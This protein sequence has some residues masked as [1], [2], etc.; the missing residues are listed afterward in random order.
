MGRTVPPGRQHGLLRVGQRGHDVVQL[1]LEGGERR[2]EAAH[3][4]LEDDVGR[5]EGGAQ[6]WSQLCKNRSSRK[7]DSRRLFSREY[8]FPKTFSLT[9]NHFSGKTYLYTIRPGLRERRQLAEDRGR[10]QVRRQTVGRH[11]LHLAED[12]VQCKY[13]GD[14]LIYD[15]LPQKQFIDKYL[16]NAP[17]F[18]TRWSIWLDSWVW[19][20]LIWAVPPSAW[21][22]LG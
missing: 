11:Q 5:E 8:D 6:H 20:T 13:S 2:V 14:H 22:C 7:T 15:R 4:R 16:F 19:L 1:L 10:Q 21:L 3:R 18:P 9:Q 17:I 12:I